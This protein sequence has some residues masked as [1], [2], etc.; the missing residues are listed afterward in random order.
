[1]TRHDPPASPLLTHCPETL[2][3]RAYYDAD[4]FGREER[5]I[6]RRNW[7]YAGRLADLAPGTMRRISIGGQNL[8]LCRDQAGAVTAFHNTC[9]HRGSELCGA[10]DRKL[11][12]LITCPYHA[13]SYATDGR[14]VSVAHATPTEDFRFEDHGLFAVHVQ[15]WNGFLYLCLAETAPAFAPDLGLHALD[16]WPMA[17][18][19]TGH[20]LVSELAC[21]WK[22]FWENYNECLH[23]P[24]IHP[25]LCDM[26]PVYSRGV[27][28]ARELPGWDGSA[29][30]GPVLKPGAE[31]WTKSGAPCGPVFAGLTDAER[32][33][34]FTF[35]TLYPAMFVVAHVDY[36]RAVSL[37]P[38]G[39]ERTRLTAEWLFPRETLDQPGFDAAAVA[40][41]AARVLMEDGAACEMNQRGLR[42]ERF[43]QGRLMPQEFDILAFH[44]WVRRQLAAE[45]G[46]GA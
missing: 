10:E 14:L 17:E 20:R 36:V 6:W 29:P 18:L 44:D 19:V 38:L 13:W 11:G 24:G 3:A 42:S 41:F 22:I 21:N 4:W 2:P 33:A 1:M 12:K 5:A 30:A 28:S 45:E 7:V 27:M 32:A 16:N 37:A 25:G 35:V 23:C 26:V 9:R 46:E 40:A 15:Q 39:P 31:T 34:G 8:L 43:A